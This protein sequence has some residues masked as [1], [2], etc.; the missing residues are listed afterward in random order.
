MSL[1]NTS[2]TRHFHALASIV[3]RSRRVLARL[4]DVIPQQRRISRCARTVVVQ[5]AVGAGG[6]D[7]AALARLV[8]AVVE[9]V[10]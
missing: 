6:V 10:A 1:C 4:A 5:D 8:V 2:S 7:G 9:V 3:A